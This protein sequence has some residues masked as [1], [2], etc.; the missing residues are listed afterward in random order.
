MGIP[1]DA[2]DLQLPTWSTGTRWLY[3]QSCGG[4]RDRDLLKSTDHDPTNSHAYGLL[5]TP[6]GRMPMLVCGFER[7][8]DLL[9][10]GQRL[11]EGDR[12]TRDA[13]RAIVA[14]HEFHY[15]GMKYRPTSR[16]RR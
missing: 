4:E 15:Q 2:V 8:G 1:S 6:Q 16:I 10:D 3:T 7:V 5:M 14:F 9:G 12:A 11:V 13:L